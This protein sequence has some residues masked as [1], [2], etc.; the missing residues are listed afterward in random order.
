M[1]RSFGQLFASSLL[2]ATN[3]LRLNRRTACVCQMKLSLILVPSATVG[4]KP[5]SWQANVNCLPTA[6]PPLLATFASCPILYSNIRRRDDDET[7]RDDR[8][9]YEVLYRR[10]RRGLLSIHSFISFLSHRPSDRSY[11][12]LLMQIVARLV[13]RAPLSQDMAEVANLQYK[14]E[15]RQI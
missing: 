2:R 6:D 1:S 11:S 10:R 13:G 12:K 5:L 9:Q 8:I 3:A 14:S 7:R 15:G 4:C